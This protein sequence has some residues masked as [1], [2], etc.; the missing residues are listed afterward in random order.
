MFLLRTNM[1]IPAITTPKHVQIIQN[2][3]IITVG[4]AAKPC[5]AIGIRIQL[6]VFEAKVCCLILINDVFVA[7]VI[8]L[9]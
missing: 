8:V 3:N 6:G 2:Y 1:Y 7:D 5:L 4:E 9:Q